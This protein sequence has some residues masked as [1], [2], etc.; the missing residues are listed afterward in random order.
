M[1]VYDISPNDWGLSHTADYTDETGCPMLA[2]SPVSVVCEVTEVKALGSHD[3]FIAKVLSVYV[4][5]TYMNQAGKFELNKTGL[6]A[7]SHG[8]YVE[9]GKELGGFGFSV[10]KPTRKKKSG[11]S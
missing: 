5:E 8:A 9:M 11:R 10:K 2:E 4:D 7:Y 1:K 6:I 3:M